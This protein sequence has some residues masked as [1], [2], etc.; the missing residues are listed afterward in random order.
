MKGLVEKG[1]KALPKIKFKFSL[2]KIK[3]IRELLLA[4][5]LTVMVFGVFFVW[6]FYDANEFHNT[7]IARILTKEQEELLFQNVLE[8]NKEEVIKGNKDIYN[9]NMNY[10]DPNYQ[11]CVKTDESYYQNF[12][13][14]N[15][16]YV[17]A[18]SKDFVIIGKGRTNFYV[19]S[20]LKKKMVS[21]GKIYKAYSIFQFIDENI[22]Y[23]LIVFG[24]LL[25]LSVLL[26]YG[27]LASVI[28]KEE[29]TVGTKLG[30]NI[31]VEFFVLLISLPCLGFIAL[32]ANKEMQLYQISYFSC[33]VMLLQLFACFICFLLF[34]E[35][36]L[37]KVV[38]GA[39]LQRSL[40][41]GLLRRV[42]KWMNPV[43]RNISGNIKAV[44]FL[45]G[46]ICLESFI[47]YFLIYHLGYRAASDFYVSSEIYAFSDIYLVLFFFLK[48]LEFC[49]LLR[50][51]SQLFYLHKV[52][53]QIRDGEVEAK[54]DTKEM[55]GILKEHGECLNGI[56]K[57][58]KKAIGEQ[59]KSEQMKVELITN[60]SHDIKTPLTSII[61]YVDLMKKEK[62][63]NPKITEYL[64]V[65]D[66]QSQRLKSL[67]EQVI[68]ASKAATGNLEVNISKLNVGEMLSQ[69]LGE[70]ENKFSKIN[71]CTIYEPEKDT[72]FAYGDGQLLWRVLDNLF[73]NVYKYTLEGT[74]F[75][76]D[77]NEREESCVVS[78]KNIS[79]YRLN[80]TSEELMQRF[81]RGDASRNT[82]GNGLGLSIAQSL[83]SLQGGE[84][85]IETNGDLFVA[86]LSLSREE[87][88]V[89]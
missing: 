24:V 78:L 54:A 18:N 67:T 52:A 81:V 7:T 21:E 69:A 1:K 28:K 75:Y 62:T 49:I 57:G 8:P 66:K 47:S 72:Y 60:V 59:M 17:E 44:A 25:F 6:A 37:S 46:M 30:Q 22:V 32:E 85:K 79:K 2:K 80:G 71:L 29:R 70:Y 56:S 89:L 87:V 11:F 84:L 16:D 35:M 64:D 51:S 61:N 86:E 83:M 53:K 41:A 39:F 88:S 82:Q 4:L 23:I 45:F 36:L 9:K 76:I 26:I 5:C 31:P 73:S 55:H 42:R 10:L 34:M 13:S 27:I 38:N 19:E 77:V 68:E 48:G 43:F 3:Y 63:D 15:A 50:F 65:L 14:W 58:L 20:Y 40:F 12:S 33:G 74:R